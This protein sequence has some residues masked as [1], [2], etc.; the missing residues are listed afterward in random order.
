MTTESPSYSTIEQAF[1]LGNGQDSAL[2]WL[3]KNR[4][5]VAIFLVSGIKLEGII[6]GFD[7][8]S[9]L[10]TDA[11]GNQQLV[12]KA[13][14]STIAMHSGRPQVSIQ[15]ARK[16]RVSMAPRPHGAPGRYDDNQGGGSSEQ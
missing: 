14:I 1:S 3:R 13:K 9:V 7:Q 8:Y 4:S 6:S 10:L 11:H 2:N 16:P 15:R 5:Q 12:Y